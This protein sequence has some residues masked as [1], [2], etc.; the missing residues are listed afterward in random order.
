MRFNSILDNRPVRS[1]IL[2]GSVASGVPIAC[3]ISVAIWLK[4]SLPVDAVLGTIIINLLLPLVVGIAMGMVWSSLPAPLQRKAPDDAVGST[5]ISGGANAGPGQVQGEWNNCCT[6]FDAFMSHLPALAF[7]KDSDGRY[8][9]SNPAFGRI[10]DM[11]PQEL[12]GRSD[13][14]LTPGRVDQLRTHD[15]YVRSSQQALNVVEKYDVDGEERS[16]LVTKFPIA[17]KGRSD[18]VAGVAFDITDKLRTEETNA[19]LQA[20]L[21]QAQR[22][23]AIGTLAG[24]IAHDFNNIL[25]AIL[26]YVELTLLDTAPE[27]KSRWQLE[28]VRTA[29]HR[30]RDLVRQILTF[31]RRNEQERKLTDIVPLLKEGLKMMR[32]SLPTTIE[33]RSDLDAS[34]ALLLADATQIHQ[35]IVNLCANAAQAMKISGG[36][37]EVRLRPVTIDPLAA[38]TKGLA[39][40][41]FLEVVVS[42]TGSGIQPD[43][44][45]RIFDPY[46]TTKTQGKGTGMG[47]A[48]VHGIVKSHGGA[49]Q[50]ES[51]PGQ[52]ACF[53]LFFPVCEGQIEITAE[54]M[55]Q[56]PRGSESILLVDDENA[57]L[58]LGK[59]MLTHLGY[60][61]ECRSDA[62][63]A[64]ETIRRQ[65]GHYDL[66]ITDMTMPHMTGDLLAQ[67]IMSIR[68]ALPVILCTGY[69]ER[70][71]E[72]KAVRIGIAA[73]LMKPLTIGDLARTIRKVLDG[74][75]D[76]PGP[77]DA[78]ETAAPLISP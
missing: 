52:G 9:Y 32:A 21:I 17:H 42:D 55:E 37:L 71:S 8:L 47:L 73:F 62:L 69:S 27:T 66:V 57:I 38:Q 51:R 48:V 22:M 5:R 14:E 77:T 68:N 58:D 4:G 61:V 18:M 30:A 26:G 13:A 70:M 46:F 7:V 24:G 3:G 34:G 65:A 53:R 67:Q 76:M 60:R 19:L 11:S 40:G 49:I 16:F 33:I 72:E 75:P 2:A 12:I 31:S 20:Q 39:P 41:R 25:A 43:H 35:V 15:E 56:L 10:F 59:Q 29:A 23:E 64:L 50:V 45:G 74:R 36:I 6:L 28:Q 44:L 78:G 1:R 54:K 63:S